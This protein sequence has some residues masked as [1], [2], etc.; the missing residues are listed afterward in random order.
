MKSK[1]IE[2][3]ES[4]PDGCAACQGPQ[5]GYRTGILYSSYT[6]ASFAREYTLADKHG[7]SGDVVIMI[8][9][10]K[11]TQFMSVEAAER[12]HIRIFAHAVLDD[13]A[14]AASLGPADAL[15]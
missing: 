15:S 9:P 2:I 4:G 6:A 3:D 11:E 12:G 10:E 1:P 8:V 7:R 14:D 13:D 5:L